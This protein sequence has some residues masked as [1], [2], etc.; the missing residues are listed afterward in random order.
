[1]R[2]LFALV[3]GGVLGVSAWHFAPMRASSA[4]VRGRYVEARTASVFAG[5]CHYNGELVTAGKEA[6]L[7]WHFDSGSVRGASLAG[8]D[9]VAVVRADD[10][11]KLATTRRSVVYVPENSSEEVRAAL[12]QVIEKQSHDQLGLIREVKPAKLSVAIGGETYAVNVDGVAELEGSLMAD[13]A[14]CSMPQSVW[15]E[16]LAKLDDRVVGKSDVFSFHDAS[17][18]APFELHGNNDSFVGSFTY[19]PCCAPSHPT[20]C[21]SM[22]CDGATPP[23]T[24]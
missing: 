21:C 15:Y 3:I 10:N 17:F 22:P 23:A 2:I 19:S 14:C 11:L 5:A 1:M 16:P 12:L 20:D 24:P 8:V 18:G 6:L 4:P 9:V 13:R 7:A